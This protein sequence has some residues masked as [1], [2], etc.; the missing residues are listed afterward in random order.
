MLQAVSLERE[1]SWPAAL[2]EYIRH[3]DRA[4]LDGGDKAL[5]TWED[6]YLPCESFMEFCDVAGKLQ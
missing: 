5:K 3:N 6:E 2:A 4:L 1:A